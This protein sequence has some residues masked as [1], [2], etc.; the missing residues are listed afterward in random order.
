M[1]GFTCVNAVGTILAEVPF[2]GSE[3]GYEGVEP[4]PLEMPNARVLAAPL[5]RE[6]CCVEPGL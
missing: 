2:G 4:L 3:R 5:L 1:N 6:V